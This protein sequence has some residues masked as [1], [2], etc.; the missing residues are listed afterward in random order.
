M[1]ALFDCSYFLISK[2][3]LPNPMSA[4]CKWITVRFEILLHLFLTILHLVSRLEVYQFGYL[5]FSQ[6]TVVVFS[7]GLHV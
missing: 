7:N 3:R 1:L 4:H 2:L 6:G 5:L